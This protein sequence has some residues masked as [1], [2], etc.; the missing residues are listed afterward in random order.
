MQ[1]NRDVTTYIGAHLYISESAEETITSH[2]VTDAAVARMFGCLMQRAE[3]NRRHTQ[4]DVSKHTRGIGIS[5]YCL[6]FDSAVSPRIESQLND[7]KTVTVKVW[8]NYWIKAHDPETRYRARDG[9]TYKFG[10][11]PG[12]A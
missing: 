2:L 12:L 11:G 4:S 6:E 1:V 9:Q 10:E 5:P 8:I 3:H 7:D